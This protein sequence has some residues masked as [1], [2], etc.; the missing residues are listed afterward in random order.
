MENYKFMRLSRENAKDVFYLFKTVKNYAGD[1][2]K[3]QKKFATSFSGA[4]YVGYFAYDRED[5]PV[6]FYGVTP[7]F[8]LA[9]K[10]KIRI[11]QAV[12][13][14]THPDHR[15][16]G[17]FEKIV[18]LTT[19]LCRDEG[20]HFI[21]GVPNDVSYQGFIKKFN[22]SQSGNLVK[23]QFKTGQL[24]ISHFCKKHHHLNKIHS[25]YI[26]LVLGLLRKGRPFENPNSGDESIIV[27][28][29]EEFFNYKN[30]TEKYL[31]K[32]CDLSIWLSV[33]GSMKIGDMTCSENVDARLLI[34]K[35]KCL[36][37]VLGISKI[38]FQSS[39]EA[40]WALKLSKSY[41]AEI[42]LPIIY[43]NLTG[44]YDPQKL[45]LSYGD[46]DSF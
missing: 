17:L 38:V 40:F 29:D 42:A 45:R 11:A 27:L 39:P 31:V 25:H 19:R 35:L 24:P 18:E 15:R 16:Q 41:R 21:Y 3:Y 32:I 10:K 43:F 7:C 20:I 34:R 30:Y 1:H 26:K 12:D 5:R 36:A 28:R 8:A 23:F 14:V 37:F 44:V 13:A 6:A 9:G 4:E 2:R 22:W 33:D 46:I